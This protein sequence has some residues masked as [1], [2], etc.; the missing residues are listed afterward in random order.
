MI[1]KIGEKF[2]N[3]FRIS[4]TIHRGFIQLFND[5]NPLH[6]NHKFATEKGFAG[7]VMHGNILNGFISYF[8]GECLPLKNVIIHSQEIQ[9]KKAV[10]L[11]DELF[12]EAVVC[13]VHESVSAVEFKFS[14]RNKDLE[15]V[16]KGKFQ[17][18][19]I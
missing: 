18:G 14:F 9:Y 6:V 16:S 12:F 7:R 19:L 3:N 5:K 8:I 10:Y 1:F 17:I 11:D 15:I 13:G 4:E 2:A